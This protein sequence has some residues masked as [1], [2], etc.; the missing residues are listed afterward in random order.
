MRAARATNTLHTG[1]GPAGRVEKIGE[2]A[3]A[4]KNPIVR[5]VLIDQLTATA[6]GAPG[7]VD[8]VLER[9]FEAGEDPAVKPRRDLERGILVLLTHLALVPQT[10]FASRT[11]ENWC[12]NAPTNPAVVEAFAQWAR[13]YLAPPGGPA[14][15]VAF[16]LLRTAADASLAR[17]TLDPRDNSPGTNPSEAELTEVRGALEVAHEIAQEIYFAS[18]AYDG[19]QGQKCSSS[20]DLVK[21]ADLAF[22]VLATCAG[23]HVAQCVHQA[24]QTMVFLAPLDEAQALRA[25]ADAVP[26]DGPYAGDP[27]AGNVI[28]PYLQRLLAEHRPLV[29]F[30]EHGVGAFRHLLATFAVAGNEAALDLAYTLAEVFR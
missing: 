14:Q 12:V 8:A 30:D 5:A 9:L 27:L 15:Q 25:I 2:L 21:F 7:T 6:N 11:I 24:V 3:L 28:I 19:N 4:E 18:G 16:G 10:P 29:L 13:S 22:P 1:L 23:L 17:S 20:G 26:A